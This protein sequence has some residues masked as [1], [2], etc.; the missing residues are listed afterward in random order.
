[1]ANWVKECGVDAGCDT[2]IVNEH[3]NWLLKKEVAE[4]EALAVEL[5][6]ERAKY[7]N[8]AIKYRQL[9]RLMVV[10]FFGWLAI[11]AIVTVVQK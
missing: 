9:F 4:G 5:A 1:M 10:V 2:C 3:Q 6:Q 7:R 8:D 11:Q